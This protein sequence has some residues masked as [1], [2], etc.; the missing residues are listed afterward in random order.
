MERPIAKNGVGDNSQADRAELIAFPARSVFRRGH[1]VKKVLRLSV[2]IGFA[3]FF[4]C[5]FAQAAAIDELASEGDQA[6][7][8]GDYQHAIQ[9]WTRV[10]ESGYVSGALYFNLGNAYY[11]TGELGRAILFYERALNEMPHSSDV[12][13]NLELA[14][15]RTVD[16]I[17]EPPRLPIWNW[18]DAARDWIAPSTL[19]WSAWVT[20]TLAAVF[21]ALSL[22]LRANY[23]VYL[24][25]RN[26]ALGT[27]VLFL[28]MLGL[29][30]LR[31]VADQRP[32]HAV[33]MTDKVVVRAAPDA[34]ARELFH[35]HE[36]TKVTVVK[37]LEG[38][39]EV[40]LVDDR[41]GWLPAGSVEQVP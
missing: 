37:T 27:G 34:K 3:L 2:F 18:L 24:A 16:R 11:K 5:V 6:Y 13:H 22:L 28:L 7:R 41:Q 36:G 14:R 4:G 31:F 30:G 15:A 20:A 35:L 12:R 39:H 19:A 9:A 21:F 26:L 17:E 10:L 29:L 33:I 32:P 40:K 25:A 38:Y 8:E 23:R 1:A